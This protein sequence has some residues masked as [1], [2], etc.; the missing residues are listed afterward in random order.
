MTG[1]VILAESHISMHSWPEHGYVAIDVFLCG[2][3]DPMPAIEVLRR[4]FRPEVVEL[5]DIKRGVRTPEE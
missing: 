5:Q 1:V 4:V 3:A 2:E